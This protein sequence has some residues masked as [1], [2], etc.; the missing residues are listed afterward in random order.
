MKGQDILKKWKLNQVM[1]RSSLQSYLDLY[2]YFILFSLVILQTL[3]LY[4]YL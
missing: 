1:K 3:H 4:M 2:G